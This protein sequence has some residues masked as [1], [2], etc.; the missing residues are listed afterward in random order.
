M[1]QVFVTGGSG[2]VG[3]N[4]IPM[5]IEEGY[6]VKALAR[7]PQAVQ[8]VEQLGAIAVRGDLTDAQQ[9][10]Q[11]LKGCESVFHLAGSVNFFASE[12]ELEKI[13]VQATKLL[14]SAAKEA[15]VKKFID[16]SASSVIMNGK[17]I[18][19]AD[20]TFQ[21]DHIV[22]GY[23]RTKLRAE[24]LVLQAHTN[25]FQTISIRP[26]MIW[27]KG[28]NNILPAVLEAIKE[29]QMQLIGGGKHHLSTAHVLNVCHALILAERAIPS[30]KAYFITDGES[31]VFKDFISQYVAT[32]GVT[33]PDKSVSL[34]MAKII[35]TIMEFVW[36][37][38]K[39]NGH[40]PLY[41]ALVNTLGLEFTLK[42]RRAREELGYKPI[43]TIQQ[44]M[45]LMNS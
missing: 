35:A 26:P 17:P 45:K 21:S 33:L 15:G 25:D 42:D 41:K 24:Q 3:Q 38:F 37:T 1:K 7:S 2:F 19:N 44:G 11:G 30:G 4:L 34:G 14:L 20:E 10:A 31:P 39:L 18:E 5:L 43:V 23:S 29:G 6:Q 16:L 9:L 22:D 13:H 12:E 28:D 40:P 32:Q 8:K 36:K 27:G